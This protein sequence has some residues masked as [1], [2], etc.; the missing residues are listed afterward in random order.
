MGSYAYYMYTILGDPRCLVEATGCHSPYSMVA[1]DSREPVVTTEDGTQAAE[2]PRNSLQCRLIN[3]A[4]G[5][6]VPACRKLWIDAI[7][8]K[9]AYIRERSS[10]YF[11]GEW[12]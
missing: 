10:V 1:S 4:K 3:A 11:S 6:H 9:A 2:A 7:D 8:K 5:Q 12:G